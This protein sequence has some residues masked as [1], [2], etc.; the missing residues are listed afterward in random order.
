MSNEKKV[1][2]TFLEKKKEFWV[3]DA[4]AELIIQCFTGSNHENESNK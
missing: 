2:S 1:Y 3:E 4:E